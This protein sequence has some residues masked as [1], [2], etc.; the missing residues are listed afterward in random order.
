[1][2]PSKVH[3]KRFTFINRVA[4]VVISKS[5]FVNELGDPRWVRSNKP[6]IHLRSGHGAQI[7]RYVSISR[8]CLPQ[9]GDFRCC[10]PFSGPPQSNFYI[11]HFEFNVVC[12]VSVAKFTAIIC[13]VWIL[14]VSLISLYDDISLFCRTHT[15]HE[16]AYKI[17]VLSLSLLATPPFVDNK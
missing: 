5:A 10:F 9:L 16:G 7:S 2:C 8:H 14:F 13:G 12:R 1:M 15:Q 17:V 11:N 4:S 6:T 3:S